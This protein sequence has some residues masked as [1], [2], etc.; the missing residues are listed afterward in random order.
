MLKRRLDLW[1]P[2]YLAGTPDRLLHRLRRR[3]RHTH[4]IFLVCDHFEPAHHVRTPEQSMNRM[5]AWHEGYADLQRRCRDEFGTTPLHSFF[6]PPHHGVE[7][8]APLAEMAYDGLGEVELHYHHHDDTEETLE[9][10]LRATL[11]EYHRWGLLLESGATPFTSF[12]FIHGDWAL[13]NSGHGKHC[14]VNDELRLLQR[15]GCW[16]DLTLPSSEQ[17]Q[18]RKVNSIYYASGD[19][20]QPKSHDHGID[21]RVGHPKPEGMMLIQGPLGINWTGASYPR[22]E[23]ASLTTP[24]WGRPDRIRKWIDC[25]VH[26]RGR[27][28]WLFIKLHTHGAIERDFDA[29]F[30]EKAMQM[31]RVLNREYNDGERFT[32]HY[33]TARQAYN[34]ARAA[35][36]GESGNPA[37]YLDYRIAPPA[38]AFYSLNTRH[39]LEACT[40]NRLRIRACESAVALR[41][42]TRVGPLQEV[43]GALEGIDIDVANRRIHLELDGPLTFL[44]QPGAMLEVVKGNAVLQSIDGEVRLDGAGP[45]ILTYR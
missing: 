37:D 21:A 10:D 38:T 2:G 40:G 23:N 14:G 12:G 19:P 42:R 8:L 30:G 26:V 13:C 4:L 31:H 18:T 11:E 6:Y 24:N 22:I 44:T 3:N 9:R 25:N 32:L 27:P 29:L 16:A 35:E 28:E 17:C 1:L 20:R 36:H 7:H 41:L 5:R 39:T 34:V 33:V 43:R 45:C 15:L